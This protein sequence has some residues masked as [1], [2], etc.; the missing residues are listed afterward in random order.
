MTEKKVV[1]LSDFFTKEVE[2]IEK[3]N[4]EK[5]EEVEK[6]ES[7]ALKAIDKA[8]SILE[9]IGISHHFSISPLSQTYYV[10]PPSRIEKMMA[11]LKN[12][13]VVLDEE[14]LS[15]EDIETTLTEWM[16]DHFG[17]GEF[18]GWQHSAVC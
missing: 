7:K 1:D 18:S 2:K 3:E 12:S 9:E 5:L 14:E 13:T 17:Y 6:L 15:E 4:K 11:K 8:V 10:D 16:N